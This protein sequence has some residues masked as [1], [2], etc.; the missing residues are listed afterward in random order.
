MKSSAT[1]NL[2]LRASP[3]M[4]NAPVRYLRTSFICAADPPL[5]GVSNESVVS[6]CGNQTYGVTAN[7]HCDGGSWDCARTGA[8]GETYA[9]RS[10]TRQRSIGYRAGRCASIPCFVC[11]A[12]GFVPTVAHDVSHLAQPSTGMLASHLPRLGPQPP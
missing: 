11:R 12:Y 2:P 3:L 8:L 9:A 10:A 6:R 1:P 5:P 7:C 4:K